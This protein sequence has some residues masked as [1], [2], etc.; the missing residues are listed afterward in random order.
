[1]LKKLLQTFVL[2]LF[3]SASA[4]AQTGTLE[5]TI[6]DANTGETLLGANVF[7]VELSRGAA[8]DV[9]GNYFVRNIPVGTYTLRSTYLG[10]KEVSQEVTIGQGANTLDIELTVDTFGLDE[11][12]V[13]GVISG[14]PRKKLAF[15]VGNVSAE[16]I[17]KVPTTDISSALQGKVAG[18]KVTQGSGA[19][20]SS[21][22]I[23][24]RGSTAIGGGNGGDQGPLVIVDGVILD[25]S[26]ADIPS[27]SIK[28]IEILKGAA[29]ASLYGSRAANGVIQV[30][31]KRGD[32]VASGKTSVVLRNEFGTSFLTSEIDLAQSH[33]YVSTEAE[34]LE[35]I[36]TA[37]INDYSMDP[38][39][40]YLVNNNG[41][42]RVTI[43]DG[44]A[45]QSYGQYFDQLDRVYESGSSMNNYI[46]VSQNNENSNFLLSFSNVTE[47]GVVKLKD[48]YERQNVRLNTDVN[49]AEGLDLSASGSYSQSGNN[50]ISQGP[51]SPFWGALF[52]QPNY[53]ILAPNEEDGSPYN[54]NAD[55]YAVEDNPLYSLNTSIFGQD[56]KRFLGNAQVRYKPIQEVLLE[57]SYSIDIRNSQNES[58]TPL[59][60]LTS[61][62]FSTSESSGSLSRTNVDNKS[63]NMS[64]TAG[65]DKHFDDLYVRVKGSYLYENSDYFSWDAGATNFAVG[66]IKSW[67]AIESG[68][69]KSVDNYNQK[70]IS[71]NVFGIVSLDYRDAYIVDFLLRRDGSSLFG[72]NERYNNYYR[73]SGAYRISEDFDLPGIDEFKVRASLGTAGLRPPFSAQ[74]LTYNINGGLTSKGTL[75]N[76]DLKPALATELEIGTNIDFLDRFSLE[77]S[78]STTEVT[79]QILSVPLSAAAGG[80]NSR[81]QNAG[82]IETST[83]EATFNYQ[84][85]QERDMSLSFGVNFDRTRQKITELS[86]PPYFQ[87]PTTQNAD[88]FYIAEGE[89]YG[90]MYGTK[91]AR[92]ISDLSS[93]QVATIGESNLTVNN[94][95]Y[96]VTD[97]GT[98]SESPVSI[99]DEDGN[100]TFKIGDVNPDFNIALNT[101]F[102]FKGFNI[103]M[104]WDAK[105]GGDIYNQTK[106]WLYR[107]DRH[108]DSDQAGVAAANQKPVGYWQSFYNTNNPSGYFVEDGTY[109][110][111][112]E[113]SLSYTLGSEQLGALGN[114]LQSIN[115]ALIGRNLLTIT[116]Y[117]GYDPEVAGAN[118]DI[119]NFAFDG[120]G[121][122]NFTQLSGSIELR[123]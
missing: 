63:E 88:V 52:M 68:D 114:A 76:P 29:A 1:M 41:F 7:L 34:L 74:Y 84:A 107:E 92:S 27:Q 61:T 8:T 58:Y 53:D 25:G 120:F 19:P 104:L 123:F 75:G 48:G 38:T 86:V 113:L 44:I 42:N 16:D 99:V 40:S 49:I 71:E 66:N 79:D 37:D 111:L 10:Y 78:Y 96:V 51:G 103:Y 64:L 110:K 4:L 80:F 15:T 77:A 94:Y 93:D 119:T 89:T 70:V 109:I 62:G 121:Y 106:Q 54:V 122:P 3:L 102:N 36:P 24:L 98:V 81:W 18:V 85:I 31:T 17:E 97:A 105:F 13:T 22:A 35:A 60:T 56:R 57:G 83:I 12:I 116:D 65:Y 117:T 73:V 55:P 100:G 95:G 21:A 82:T 14:T 46:S 87:G 47:S 43:A 72:E 50:Q 118:G 20:G 11:V 67:D 32:D 112:R 59:G 9:D 28:N 30:F 39:G 115:L 23:R 6:T 108:G 5:G 33:V 90:V 101:N 69:N 26:L 45:D 2:L 91:W